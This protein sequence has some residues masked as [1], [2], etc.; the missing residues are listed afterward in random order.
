MCI[1]VCIFV[2]G[3]GV[4]EQECVVMQ[5]LLSLIRWAQLGRSTSAFKPYCG[6]G[7]Y[8]LFFSQVK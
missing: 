5:G 7:V 8:I 6:V 2:E 1:Y 3:V 4:R